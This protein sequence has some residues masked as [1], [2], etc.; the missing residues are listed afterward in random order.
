MLK[1]PLN[2]YDEAGRLK[3]P[4]LAYIFLLFVCRGLLILIVSLSFREDSERLLRTFYP[5]P[6]H[7]YLALLPI[8]PAM[9]ALSIISRRNSLWKSENFKWFSSLVLLGCV[10]LIIDVI[11]QFYILNQMKFNFSLSHGLSILI[12][13]TGLT[14]WLRSTYVNNLIADWK[15]P[16]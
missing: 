2:K 12:G 4:I 9:I 10:A 13:I 1:Y 3:P 7:F 5:E 14:Y 15:A 8:L 6:Y 11:V 16:N